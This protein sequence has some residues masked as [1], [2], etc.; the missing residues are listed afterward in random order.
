MPTLYLAC[1]FFG[2]L[3]TCF[4]CYVVHREAHT[5]EERTVEHQRLLLNDMSLMAHEEDF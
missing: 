2:I 5:E 4:G 3:N 1:V